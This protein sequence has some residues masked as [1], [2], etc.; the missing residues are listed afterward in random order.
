MWEYIYIC[1]FERFGDV[2]PEKGGGKVYLLC[3]NYS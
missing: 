3:L 1:V 2:L